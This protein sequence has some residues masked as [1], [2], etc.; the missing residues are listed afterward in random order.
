MPRKRRAEVESTARPPGE[1]LAVGRIVRPHG[2]RG[3]LLFEA[4][5]ELVSVLAPDAHVFVGESKQPA[6]ILGVRKHGKRY[7]LELK[8]CTSLEAAEALRSAEVRVAAE[9]A[10]A[11]PAGTYFHWQILGLTVITD[12]GEVLGQVAEI[13]ATGANDVYLVRG[14]RDILLPATQEVVLQVDPAAGQMIVHLL[15]GLAD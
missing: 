3:G 14:E 8:G 1:T 15:P 7:L 11:L 6:T 9:Q 2:V 10:P 12:Q 13:L 4:Y 5:S